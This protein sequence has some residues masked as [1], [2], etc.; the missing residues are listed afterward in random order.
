MIKKVTIILLCQIFLTGCAALQKET[1]DE[2]DRRV[3]ISV[4][5]KED[6]KVDVQ[7]IRDDEKTGKH[8][9]IDVTPN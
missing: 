4:N 8:Q 9:Q 1:G 2:V 7:F 5:C 3:L 6:S